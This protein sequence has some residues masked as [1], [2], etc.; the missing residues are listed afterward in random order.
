MREGGAV[1]P[2]DGSEPLLGGAVVGQQANHI[3]QGDAFAEPFPETFLGNFPF[4]YDLLIIEKYAL[5][6]S[7]KQVNLSLLRRFLYS[8]L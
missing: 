2:A 8:S 1:E 5:L 6:I 7:I 4:L 3:G